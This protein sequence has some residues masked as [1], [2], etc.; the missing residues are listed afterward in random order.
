M[1]INLSDDKM[2]DKSATISGCGIAYF[3]LV[4]D[5]LI[6]NAIRLGF[7]LETASNLS[8]QTFI[9]TA[10]LLED[11][12][13]DMTENIN[14]IATKGGMTREALDVLI[15]KGLEAIFAEAIDKAVQ[16]ADQFQ[17]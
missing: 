16:K 10:S 14:Q 8:I 9:G 11:N 15:E 1:E 5:I 12:A 13:K 7:P 2:L 4:L 6:K 17:G 3:Y